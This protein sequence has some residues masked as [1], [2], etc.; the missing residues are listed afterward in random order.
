MTSTERNLVKTHETEGRLNL[1]VVGDGHTK[2]KAGTFCY[3]F[4]N[5]PIDT[6]KSRIL[7]PIPHLGP[8]RV[9]RGAA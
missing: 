1:Y 6:V 7:D 5:K 8:D 9:K 2:A 4:V 3:L